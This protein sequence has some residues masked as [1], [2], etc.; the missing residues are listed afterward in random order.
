MNCLAQSITV[1]LSIIWLMTQIW[2]AICAMYQF[3][4]R[5]CESLTRG[6][7]MREQSLGLHCSTGHL[8]YEEGLVK[9]KEIMVLEQSKDP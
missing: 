9:D 5:Q 4:L 6:Q 1:C 2:F 3:A 7:G 8:S